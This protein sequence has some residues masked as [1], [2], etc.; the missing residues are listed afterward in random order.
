MRFKN[1]LF[2]IVLIICTKIVGARAKPTILKI[3]T[4]LS[5]ITLKIL[6]IAGIKIIILTKAIPIKNAIIVFLL[7]N[8]PIFVSGKSLLQLKP[9][10]NL[11]KHSTRN[12]NVVAY[13]SPIF[14]PM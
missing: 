12:A 11:A 13:P 3:C 1:Y 4:P 9:L 2:F 6:P 8:N 14:I 7:V 5:G 10:N